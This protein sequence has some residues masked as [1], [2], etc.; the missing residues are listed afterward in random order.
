MY[1]VSHI[2]YPELPL[3]DYRKYLVLLDYDAKAEV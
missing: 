3:P 2:C 1:L